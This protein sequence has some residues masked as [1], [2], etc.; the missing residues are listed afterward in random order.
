M[1]TTKSTQNL[2]VGIAS[3]A[4]SAMAA[5][6]ARAAADKPTV[7]EVTA[8][9]ENTST[10]ALTLDNTTIN[11]RPKAVLI[12]TQNWVGNYN[13]HSVGVFYSS[14]LKKWQIINEDLTPIPIGAIFNVRALAAATTNTFQLDAS[15]LNSVGDFTIINH[16]GL[17]AKPA[18]L[19]LLTHFINPA[20]TL[21]G[22]GIASNLGV[23]YDG[24]AWAV[25]NEAALPAA[26]AAYNLSNITGVAG[27]SVQTSS[28]ANIIGTSFAINDPLANNNRNAVVFVT[29]NFNP[30]GVGGE[31]NDHPVGVSYDSTD[32]AW[33]IFN[34]DQTDMAVGESFNVQVYAGPTP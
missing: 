24:T 13:P 32:D 20:P 14:A 5:G 3:I 4:I 28:V 22:V 27:A 7:F 6:Q 2:L 34:E 33:R 8:T 21:L 23:F 16:V 18:G 29:H 12:V 30:G 10:F 19:A 17:N 26:A 11:A 1:K 15:V 9:A 31:A 25:Y